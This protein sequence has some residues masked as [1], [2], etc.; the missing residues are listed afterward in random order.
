M[1][2]AGNA[3]GVTKWWKPSL[4]SSTFSFCCTVPHADFSQSWLDFSRTQRVCPGASLIVPCVSSLCAI[5]HCTACF[6]L[7]RNVIQ[8]F[9]YGTVVAGQQD[10]AGHFLIWDSEKGEWWML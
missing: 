7:T 6:Y 9:I 8:L 1:K 3:V 4:P 10:R 5:P 2:A